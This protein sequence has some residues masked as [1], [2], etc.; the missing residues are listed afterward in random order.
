MSD[1]TAFLGGAAFAGLAALLLLKG[2]ISVGESHL[3]PNSPLQSPTNLP[4]VSVLPPAPPMTMASPQPM[5]Y[6]LG[7]DRNETEQLKTQLEK[8]RTET[9]QL[10]AQLQNQQRVIEALTAQMRVNNA[11]TQARALQ[12][13]ADQANNSLPNAI[14]WVLGGMVLTVAG[15]IGL[16]G[17][18]ALASR[19]PRSPRTVEVIHSMDGYSPYLP[20]R[21]RSQV[22]P[23]RRVDYRRIDPIE[24]DL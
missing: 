3:P 7:Q 12:K 8:Q 1:T 14:L 5:P 19:P 17:V 4:P 21:R 2:G 15:G 9:E 6:S 10:K 11:T 13:E 16:A 23:P 18:L 24:Q 22:L 20:A